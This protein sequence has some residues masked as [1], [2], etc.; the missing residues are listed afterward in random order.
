[1]CTVKVRGAPLLLLLIVESIAA[2]T[3]Y[4]YRDTNG[5][6]VYADRAPAS[7]SEQ[8]SITLEHKDSVLH[9]TVEPRK[10]ADSTDLVAVSNC[11]CPVTFNVKILQSDDPAIADN[12]EFHVLVPPRSELTIVRIARRPNPGIKLQYAVQAIPGSPEA[13]HVPSRPYRVPFDVGSTYMVS[14]A[15]PTRITHTTPDSMYAIDMALPD[16]TPVY[17]AREGV[18]INVRHDA[19][20]GALAPVMLDQAN[21][22]EIL[23]DDGTMAIYAHLHWDSIRVRIGDKVSRGTYIANSGNTGFSSGPHLHFAVVRSTGDAVVSVPV[24]FAGVRDIPVTAQTR[25]PL[26][27]Y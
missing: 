2:Q 26:T 20:M 14:Q 13:R 9:I 3:A 8:S 17:A 12:S 7:T 22:V 25:M 10:A 11:L 4:R 23:H 27:A 18:V 1:L 21:V 16:G 24:Q 15:Y 5:Q 6:W 19:F